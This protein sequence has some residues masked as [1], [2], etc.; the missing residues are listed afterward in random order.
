MFGSDRKIKKEQIDY[1]L[2]LKP[3][4]QTD[5]TTKIPVKSEEISQS[6][7]L[8]EKINNLS[9]RIGS[10]EGKMDV[11]KDESAR[12]SKIKE[13]ILSLLQQHKKLSSVEL[14]NLVNLSRTRSNEYFKELSDERLVEG[15]IVGRQKYYKL[16]KK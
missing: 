7:E 14:S 2:K 4:V 8:I 3:F 12:K 5:L 6:N 1:L 13:Q 16:V 11:E 15:V 10:L 9:E